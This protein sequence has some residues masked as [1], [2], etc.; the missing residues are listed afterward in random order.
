M[1]ELS[2]LFVLVCVNSVTWFAVT[3]MMVRTAWCLAMNVTTIEGWEI[4][5]HQALVQKARTLGGF[6]YGPGGVKARIT[7]QEFPYDVGIWENIKL[8][9]GGSGNILSWAWPLARTPS[10]RSGLDFPVNGFEDPSATWPPPDPERLAREARVPASR[11]AF[12]F[13][14]DHLSAAEQMAAF[15]GRQEEDT[16]RRRGPGQRP[17]VDVNVDEASFP[18]QGEINDESS[19]NPSASPYTEYVEGVGGPGDGGVGYDGTHEDHQAQPSMPRYQ[20]SWRDGD[21]QRLEDFGVDEDAEGTVL[22]PTEEGHGRHT[23]PVPGLT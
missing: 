3:V 15:R 5:R 18:G 9:M 16:R 12:T 1:P 14:E 11:D 4:E 7:K 23:V 20:R 6:V 17:A 2:L 19:A 10:I 8:G 22:V 13:G 21:G